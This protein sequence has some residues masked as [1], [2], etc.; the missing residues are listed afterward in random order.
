MKDSEISKAKNVLD[1]PRTKSHDLKHSDLTVS[2]RTNKVQEI[3][4]KNN[5]IQ[6]SFFPAEGVKF[7]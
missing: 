4:I 5:Y 1:N 2:A 6:K 3:I 7:S